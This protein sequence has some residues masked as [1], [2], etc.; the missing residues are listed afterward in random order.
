MVIGVGDTPM[1]VSRR[2]AEREVVQSKFWKRFTAGEAEIAEDEVAVG[3]LGIRRRL[4]RDGEQKYKTKKPGHRGHREK[5]EVKIV[6]NSG[7]STAVHQSSKSPVTVLE[8]GSCRLS[9]YSVP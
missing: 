9:L 3:R 4:C 6:P 8:S 1:R 5:P 7:N 2:R